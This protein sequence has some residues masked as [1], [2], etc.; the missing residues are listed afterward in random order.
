MSLRAWEE[1]QRN[2]QSLSHS[3]SGV[4]GRLLQLSLFSKEEK[5]LLLNFI[6]AVTV[7][8]E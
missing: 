7:L 4:E 3:Q 8:L 6:E 2:Q 5:Q 1:K